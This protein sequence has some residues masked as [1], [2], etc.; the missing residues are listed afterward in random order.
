MNKKYT[1]IKRTSIISGLLC[2]I[3]FVGALLINENIWY[4]STIGYG[5]ILIYLCIKA[6]KI[7][8]YSK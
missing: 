7:E 1:S 4:V 2:L 6:M 5:I 8:V 3:G